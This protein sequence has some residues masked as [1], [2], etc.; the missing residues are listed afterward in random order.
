[1]DHHHQRAITKARVVN[2]DTRVV[3]VAVFDPFIH[4]VRLCHTK[5]APQEDGD[6]RADMRHLSHLSHR[7]TRREMVDSGPVLR[8]RY[9]SAN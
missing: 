6:R 5:C 8:F 9:R 7:V 4:I 2:P 3:R 1:M